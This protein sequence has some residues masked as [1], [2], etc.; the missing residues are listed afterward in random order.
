M[1]TENN[2]KNLNVPNKGEQSQTCLGYAERKE[3]S[4]QGNVPNLRFP[5]F[6]GEWERCSL[7]DITTNFSRRNKEEVRYPMFSVTNNRGGCS[8]VRAI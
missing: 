1:A 4:P 7:G 8:S 3:Q 6:N 5:E 2:N